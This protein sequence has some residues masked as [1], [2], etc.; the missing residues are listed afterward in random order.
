MPRPNNPQD[1]ERRRFEAPPLRHEKEFSP[2]ALMAMAG[3][4]M[5]LIGA[6]LWFLGQS[7]AG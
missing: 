6:G 1:S 4:L 7:V 5:V 3:L 2:V